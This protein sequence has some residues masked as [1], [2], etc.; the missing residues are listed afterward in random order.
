[1][2]GKALQLKQGLDERLLH[3]FL[4]ERMLP[5]CVGGY[6]TLGHRRIIER[7]HLSYQCVLE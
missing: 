7:E 1:M 6:P 3:L 5:R 4:R 2:D